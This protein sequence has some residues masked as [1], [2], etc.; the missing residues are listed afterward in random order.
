MRLFKERVTENEGSH[1][2]STGIFRLFR[3][4]WALVGF[5]G[6]VLATLS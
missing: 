6:L 5:S 1:C 4:R 2:S 3:R